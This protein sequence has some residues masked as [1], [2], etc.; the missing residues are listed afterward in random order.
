[1]TIHSEVGYE[2]REKT[3]ERGLAVEFT[4]LDI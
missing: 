1:M 3:D 2:L 4:H